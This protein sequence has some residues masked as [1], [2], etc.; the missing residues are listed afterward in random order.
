[1]Q[2]LLPSPFCRCCGHNLTRP[3][4]PHGPNLDERCQQSV[5]PA[6]LQSKIVTH[7]RR[8]P[9]VSPQ[10]L[11]E[12]RTI[13]A[14]AGSLLSLRIP[15]MSLCL[16]RIPPQQLRHQP[17]RLARHVL[18][19]PTTPRIPNNC[20]VRQ[21]YASSIRHR[22]HNL[23]RVQLPMSLQSPHRT[24]T[25]TARFLDRSSPHPFGD[26]LHPQT[27]YLQFLPLTFASPNSVSANGLSIKSGRRRQGEGRP[28][29]VVTSHAYRSKSTP[30]YNFFFRGGKR[31]DVQNTHFCLL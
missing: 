13:V 30:F 7:D 5:E 18:G 1:M 22:H 10:H 12:T 3:N 4:L 28:P 16:G 25:R 23:V 31:K 29:R 14:P 24:V 17:L 20:P 8:W 6:A 2:N 15:P 21:F 19:I 11:D 9:S 26:K 27:L